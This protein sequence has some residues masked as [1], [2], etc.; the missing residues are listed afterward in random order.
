[1]SVFQCTVGCTGAAGWWFGLLEL[2]GVCSR[3]SAVLWVRS[4]SSACILHNDVCMLKPACLPLSTEMANV[5]ASNGMLHVCS[6]FFFFYGG[7]RLSLNAAEFSLNGTLWATE[8]IRRLFFQ[9]FYVNGNIITLA[10]LSLKNKLIK[11][12]TLGDVSCYYTH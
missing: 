6:I 1:M 2:E 9:V 12:I 7:L 5:F 4:C 8:Q 10:M 11:S 3:S